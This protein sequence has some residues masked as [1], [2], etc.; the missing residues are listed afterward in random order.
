MEPCPHCNKELNPQHHYVRNSL[1]DLQKALL[2][3]ERPSARR[4]RKFT[5]RC[6]HCGKTYVSRTFRRFGFVT[7][8]N[9]VLVVAIVCIVA[10][11]AILLA[12]PRG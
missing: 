5:V 9:Y 7:Y 12:R 8:E 6:P 10:V 4:A 3:W 1:I 2:G 11:A